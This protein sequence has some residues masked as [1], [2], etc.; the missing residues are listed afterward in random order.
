M[1]SD[2]IAVDFF[3]NIPPINSRKKIL[4]SE[5]YFDVPIDWAMIVTDVKGSTLAIEAGQ[6][7][8][9]NVIGVSSIIAVQ[10]A[11]PGLEFP[12]IFGGDGATLFVPSKNIEDVKKALRTTQLTSKHEFN[13]RKKIPIK[14]C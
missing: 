8:Q 13:L 7:K 10:N 3:K 12:F 1:K 6:Y 14:D 4:A 2:L 5:F 9:V 11:L